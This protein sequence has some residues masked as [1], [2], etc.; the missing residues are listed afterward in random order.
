M[1]A[2]RL[3]DLIE[4][5]SARFGLHVLPTRAIVRQRHRDLGQREMIR[6]EAE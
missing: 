1:V 6:L 4:E 2:T 3:Q 5:S